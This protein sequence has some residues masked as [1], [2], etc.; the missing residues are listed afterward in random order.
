MSSSTIN[1]LRKNQPLNT[2]TLNDL[3]KILDCQIQDICQYIVSD[4]DQVL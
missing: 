3:C 4:E 2:A 1:K